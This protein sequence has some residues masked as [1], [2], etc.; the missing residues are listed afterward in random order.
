MKPN[1]YNRCLDWFLSVSVLIEP[2]PI[3]SLVD[4]WE[5]M[6][7]KQAAAWRYMGSAPTNLKDALDELLELAKASSQ[8]EEVRAQT[9]F[10]RVPKCRLASY[11]QIP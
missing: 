7:P 2:K 11:V 8:S 1:P 5:H 4:L 9:V 10:F 3:S 6:F